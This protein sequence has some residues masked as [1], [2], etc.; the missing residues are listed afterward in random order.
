MK[1]QKFKRQLWKYEGNGHSISYIEEKR[2]DKFFE[3]FYIFGDSGL[4]AVD[5]TSKTSSEVK[6]VET[7]GKS[8]EPRK[9]HACCFNK[10][11][12]LLCIS[13]GKDSK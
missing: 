8:P 13:G 12:R 10:N 6:K 5:L 1:Q 9:G 4:R 11:L 2:G 3:G 7:L